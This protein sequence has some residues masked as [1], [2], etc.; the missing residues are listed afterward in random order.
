MIAVSPAIAV[1]IAWLVFA[2]ISLAGLTLVL[3]WAIR[4]G[5]FKNQDRARYLALDCGTP[6][7]DECK[8][9]PQSALSRVPS[10]STL[11]GDDPIMAHTLKQTTTTL[12]GGAQA[13][14][15]TACDD[16]SRGQGYA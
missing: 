10:P 4:T 14:G 11:G 6:Q 15:T 8:P 7:D 5:Q 13:T 16:K 12:G 1:L 2:G 3:V 9:P